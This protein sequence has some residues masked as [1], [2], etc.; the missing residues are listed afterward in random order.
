MTRRDYYHVPDAPK[1][2]RI[3][4][5]VSA[6]VQ[7]GAGEIVLHRR[8]D[9]GFWSLPGGGIEVGESVTDAILREVREETGLVVAVEG[10]LGVYSDPR[11]VIAYSDGEV[12]QQ[13]SICFAC[14]VVSGTLQ[15]SD[16]ST[17]VRFFTRQ[18]ITDLNIHP[19][20]RARIE[21][22]FLDSG[23]PFIR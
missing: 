16:E 1:P 6:V 22:F 2:N 3:V 11:H 5:A 17:A 15:A 14:K 18:A 8:T 21:D 13:F 9:N 20:N 7:N 19:A 4:P 12:R 10:L 23:R